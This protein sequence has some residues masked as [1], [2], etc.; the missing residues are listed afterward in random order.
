MLKQRSRKSTD[1]NVLTDNNINKINK[2]TTEYIPIKILQNI[3]TN[4]I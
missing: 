3:A 1:P 2:Y 4:K